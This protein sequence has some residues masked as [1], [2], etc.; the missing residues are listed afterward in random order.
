MEAQKGGRGDGE[1][2]D[3]L[4]NNTFQP[5]EALYVSTRLARSGL[6]LRA[7]DDDTNSDAP[8]VGDCQETIEVHCI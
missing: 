5:R 4:D 1:G 8:L 6:G 2:P 3:F 7:L